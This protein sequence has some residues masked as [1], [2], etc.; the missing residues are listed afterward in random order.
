MRHTRRQVPYLRKQVVIAKAGLGAAA[1][2]SLRRTGVPTNGGNASPETENFAR[3]NGPRSA[4]RPRPSSRRRTLSVSRTATEAAL[5]GA[6]LGRRSVP[7]PAESE[8]PGI[9]VFAEL[10]V[11]R[12]VRD[13]RIA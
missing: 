9:F 5:G 3:A 12:L 1:G 4:T 8:L 11:L 2:S 6:V 10:L 13:A 7:C